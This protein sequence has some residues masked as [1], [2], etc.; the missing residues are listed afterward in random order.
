MLDFFIIVIDIFFLK[1]KIFLCYKLFY[2]KKNIILYN[3]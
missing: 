1:V 2:E 3:Y